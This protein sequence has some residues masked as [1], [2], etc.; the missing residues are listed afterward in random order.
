MRSAARVLLLVSCVLASGPTAHANVPP[1]PPP[2]PP[3][4]PPAP[5][6]APKPSPIPPPAAPDAPP[7][8]PPG[9]SPTSPSGR[10]PAAPAVPDPAKAGPAARASFDFETIEKA[11]SLPTGFIVLDGHWHVT[12]EADVKPPN[13]ILRQDLHVPEYAVVLAT[14]E[15][16]AFSDGVAR[17][18]FRPESGDEDASGGIVFRATDP[19][20]Y[21]LARA[22]AVEG[23]FRLYTVHNGFRRQ[24]ASVDIEPPSLNRWHTIEVSFV[25]S[26]FEATLDGKD[27]V[28]ATNETLPP[29]WCGLWTK[30]DS[31]TS[32]DDLE[33][34]PT[35]HEPPTPSPSPVPQ[36]K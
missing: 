23:N 12:N 2:K 17:V 20:N 8:P 18:R 36:P 19:R 30:S 7:A 21:G 32:F 14:G 34:V 11:T 15:G 3:A 4:A 33:I 24:I 28:S 5:S 22:N 13:S 10:A 6:D 29:G 31:V 1:I 25:G 26:R 9:P 35:K 16:R 27:R